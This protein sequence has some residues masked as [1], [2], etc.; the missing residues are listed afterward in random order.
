MIMA[1][2][3]LVVASQSMGVFLAGAF[4]APRWSMSIASLWG[5]VSFSISGFSFPI[6]GMSG[7]I[8]AVTNL[9]PL[10]HYFMIYCNQAL[11]GYPIAEA[12]IHYAA[13]LAFLILPL[14]V[15]KR[16]KRALTN[17]SYLE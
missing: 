11:L 4:P 6:E 5:V 14:L 16:L 8:R 13:L 15:I 9:F 3:L 12:A 17:F 10:R 7:A 2:L 1:S